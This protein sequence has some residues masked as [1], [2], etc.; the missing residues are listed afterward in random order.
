ME[1][2]KIGVRDLRARLVPDD[3]Y[4]GVVKILCAKARRRI[5]GSIFIV[6]FTQERNGGA[7]VSSLLEDIADAKRRAVDVRLMIGGSRTNVRIQDVTE[8]AYLRCLQ[9]GIP[10]RLVSRKADRDS[11]KKILV[12]DDY[13]LLGSHNWSIGAF[14]GQVQDSILFAD[15]RLAAYFANTL[16]SEWYDLAQK[17]VYPIGLARLE[18]T[19]AFAR[20]TPKLLRTK[21][22][23]SKPQSEAS[24]V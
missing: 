1:K 2:M 14:S 18:G 16:R 11:H 3:K 6:D 4:L 12:I 23:S 7:L 9:L 13:V 17:R 10:C 19:K 21:V 15:G 5:C 20:T 24:N 22:G 8:A